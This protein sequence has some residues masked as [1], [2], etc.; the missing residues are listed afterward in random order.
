MRGLIPIAVQDAYWDR[1][2]SLDN[3]VEVYF[4]P[5]P[6]PGDAAI[7]AETIDA[8]LA[9]PEIASSLREW[10]SISRVVGETL[11]G[12]QQLLGRDILQRIDSARGGTQ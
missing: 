1:C 11:T 4:Y 7:D 8:I 10:T 5:C 6:S 2:Y 9:N 3:A 12:P